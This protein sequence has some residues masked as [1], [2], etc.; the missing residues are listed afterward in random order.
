VNRSLAN[1]LIDLAA[2]MLFV[3][4]VATG[5][6]LR[7]PLPPGTNRTLTMWG[8]TRHRWGDIH[9]WISF[10]L[11][12]FVAIH[13]VLHWN[14][15]V[16]VVGKRLR[17]VRQPH[18]SMLH[19]GILVT[20]VLTAAFSLF[21]FAAHLGVKEL[22]EPLHE[23]EPS[24]DSEA[25]EISPPKNSTTESTTRGVASWESVYSVFE[26]RCIS[27]HGPKRQLGDFRVDQRECFFG[28]DDK[29]PLVVPG[30]AMKSPLIAIVSGAR[31]EMP[32]A[33]KHRLPENEVS[34]LTTWIDVGAN[35][36]AVQK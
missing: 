6:I 36:P 8:L 21:A 24:N 19:S 28:E 20:G 13:L 18:P 34:L 5:Y 26:N 32:M 27:C 31:P 15:V 22:A 1:V 2:A 4:M 33:D 35:W 14:W 17:L 10:A 12:A 23:L 9:Y 11:L 3:A 30:N 7:F 25:G 29:R 16:T